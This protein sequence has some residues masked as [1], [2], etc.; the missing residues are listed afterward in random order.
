MNTKLYC[1][2]LPEAFAFTF[3]ETHVESTFGLHSSIW[4]FSLDSLFP[5]GTIATLP[6]ALLTSRWSRSFYFRR[7]HQ[8]C[9]ARGAPARQ[10]VRG[11]MT[12]RRSSISH[13]S[14]V[15]PLRTTS[16]VSLS[17]RASTP[18]LTSR[19][20]LSSSRL[21]RR[22]HRTP[23]TNAR[24]IRRT[25]SFSHPRSRHLSRFH[26]VTRRLCLADPASRARASSPSGCAPDPAPIDAHAEPP[27]SSSVRTASDRAHTAGNAHRVTHSHSTHHHARERPHR[28]A[29]ARGDVRGAL[30]QGSTSST[31]FSPMFG[32]SRGQGGRV[33]GCVIVNARVIR[34]ERRD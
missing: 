29:R 20:R 34:V 30:V 28:R 14:P 15:T 12:P 16:S 3:R 10:P 4:L 23:R 31:I 27:P 22:R 11:P 8:S 19:A 5:C 32:R 33:R 18:R 26:D 7:I 21:Q 25:I 9:P 2:K 6:K 13:G 24:V 17:R 1:F